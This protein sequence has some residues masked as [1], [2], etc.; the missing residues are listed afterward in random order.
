MTTET[1]I[2]PVIA[3]KDD[4]ELLSANIIYHLRI[5]VKGI[6]VCVIPSGNDASEMLERYVD[7]PQIRIMTAPSQDWEVFDWRKHMVDVAKEEFHPEFII[8]IDPDEFLYA[9]DFDRLEDWKPLSDCYLINRYNCISSLKSDFGFPS[10]MRDCDPMTVVRFPLKG[11]EHES[12]IN[13]DAI[14]LYTA[15]APKIITK[16]SI[17]DHFI[18][19]SHSAVDSNGMLIEGATSESLFLLHFPFTTFERFNQKVENLGELAE[20]LNKRSELGYAFHW[21]RWAELLTSGDKDAVQTE[22]DVQT[23]AISDIRLFQHL[24]SATAMAPN[25]PSSFNSEEM[26]K[27]AP[28]D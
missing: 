5:G 15:V 8:N 24:A 3:V 12:K 7:H 6:V 27:A 20:L 9:P 1:G 28:N 19:G 16:A 18:G 14:W 23:A 13:H 22:F 21:K 26:M 17:L 4:Y 2:V 25:G 11:I 10:K